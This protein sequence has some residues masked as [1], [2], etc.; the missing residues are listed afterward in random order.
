MK[1]S[2]FVGYKETNTK[3]IFKKETPKNEAIVEFDINKKDLKR[4]H[5]YMKS[6]FI[7]YNVKFESYNPKLTLLLLDNVIY[8]SDRIE[9]LFNKEFEKCLIYKQLGTITVINS[10]TKDYVLLNF[11][12]NENTNKMKK[13]FNDLYIDVNKEFCYIKMFEIENGKMNN[14]MYEDMMASCPKINEIK[15]ENVNIRR[16]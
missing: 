9:K 12:P 5:D 15:L 8:D 11:V 14:R 16:I 10:D 7:R 6:W 3:E 13:F 2:K 4:I 1:F